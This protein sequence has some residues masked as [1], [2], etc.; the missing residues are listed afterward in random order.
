MLRWTIHKVTSG[1]TI[2]THFTIVSLVAETVPSPQAA[3]GAPGGCSGRRLPLAPLAGAKA[4]RARLSAAARFPGVSTAPEARPMHTSP[5]H[6][7]PI[8]TSAIHPSLNQTPCTLRRQAAPYEN[9]DI[10]HTNIFG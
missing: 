1:W 3:G 2:S 4:A 8:H 9:G 5:I 6:P 7:P 10:E